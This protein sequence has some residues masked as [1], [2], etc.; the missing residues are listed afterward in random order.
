M[1]SFM[2]LCVTVGDGVRDLIPGLIRKF[3]MSLNFSSYHPQE[4]GWYMYKPTFRNVCYNLHLA[5]QNSAKPHECYNLIAEVAVNA[6]PVDIYQA[7]FSSHMTWEQ[8]R[9]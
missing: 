9:L 2:H 7:V 8:A 3:R 6:Q 1:N 4:G 5:V